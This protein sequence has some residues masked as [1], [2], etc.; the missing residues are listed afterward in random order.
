MLADSKAIPSQRHFHN[1]G[2][3][4]LNIS[5]QALHMKSVLPSQQCIGG[6]M[7]AQGSDIGAYMVNSA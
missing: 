4:K 3:T 6:H 7:D 1:H 5:L 2:E